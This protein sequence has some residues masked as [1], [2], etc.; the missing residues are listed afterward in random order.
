MLALFT[1]LAGA[2]GAALLLRPN[3]LGLPALGL[4]TPGS[5]GPRTGP[6]S[7]ILCCCWRGSGMAAPAVGVTCVVMCRLAGPPPP[8]PAPAPPPPP[9]AQRIVISHEHGGVARLQA[10]HYGGV[11]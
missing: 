6:G 8:P 1:A 10:P 3:R 7:G 11:C 2:E 4:V 9:P 5:P